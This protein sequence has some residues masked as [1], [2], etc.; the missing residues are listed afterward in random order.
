MGFNDIKTGDKVMVWK[1]GKQLIPIETEVI[2]VKKGKI[3][4]EYRKI[5]YEGRHWN[6]LVSDDKNKLKS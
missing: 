2:G 6:N 1:A 3:Q 5:W 4:V